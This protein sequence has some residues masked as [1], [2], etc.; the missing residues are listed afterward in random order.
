MYRFLWGWGGAEG[1]DLDKLA[2]TR[3]LL[4]GA[5]QLLLSIAYF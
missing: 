5:G 3:C 1:L 2:T 4:L